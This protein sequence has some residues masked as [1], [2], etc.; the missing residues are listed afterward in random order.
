MADARQDVCCLEEGQNCGN[1]ASCNRAS[2]LIDAARYFRLLKEMLERARQSILIIG[3][4]FDGAICLNGP[5][6]TKSERLGALLRRLVEQKPDLNIR[7]LIWSLSVLHS[8]GNPYAKLFGDG[9]Q[10][11]PRISFR[12]DRQH[13]FYA[14]H[15]QKIVAIDDSIAFVGGIDLTVGRRDRRGHRFAALRRNPDGQAYGPVHDLQLMV[16][17]P[18]AQAIGTMARK[19]WK[20]GT[21][22]EVEAPKPK[23]LWP[24]DS[25]ADFKDA[26]IGISCTSPPWH[27]RPALCEGIR[28]A[29][30]MLRMARHSIYIE[31][32]YFTAPFLADVLCPALE[33]PEGPEIVLVLSGHWVSGIER[34]IFAENRNRLL[35]RLK[36]ADRHGR[37]GAFYPIIPGKDGP[38]TVLV[39]AK[40]II[41]DDSIL[42]IGSSNLNNRSTGLDAECDLAIEAHS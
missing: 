35:R 33:A 28:L 32:Q 4:D 8:P 9:W 30:D 37:L 40:L 3:W 13:P 12:L 11:H 24:A 42:R 20:A 22:E 31:A 1:V 2:L 25:G 10:K 18:A 23:R 38:V 36:R 26:T 15:H 34:L 19:R 29:S 17:G 5:G 27:G 39:H 6:G 14:C 21:G 41:A 16:D 7:I